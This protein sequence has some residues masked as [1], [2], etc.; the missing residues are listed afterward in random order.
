MPLVALALQNILQHVYWQIRFN[1]YA[2]GLCTA[3]LLLAPLS[4]GIIVT[5]IVENLIPGWYLIALG[6]A[7]IPGL[8]D[9]V[10]SGNKLTRA[11]LSIHRFSSRCVELL[12]L[13][14]VNKISSNEAA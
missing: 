13:S 7:I 5:S 14:K 12:G 9:T 1:Q 3:I 11:L 2:P 8:V 6:V 10:R 4:L